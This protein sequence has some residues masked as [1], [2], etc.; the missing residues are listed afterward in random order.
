MNG[1]PPRA[2]NPMLP[3]M[4]KDVYAGRM[5]HIFSHQSIKGC[6]RFKKRIELNKRFGEQ[7]QFERAIRRDF[8]AS[9]TQVTNSAQCHTLD[10]TGA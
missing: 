9:P 2:D 4:S 10:R 3:L 6:A 5:Q 8:A 7:S 1:T